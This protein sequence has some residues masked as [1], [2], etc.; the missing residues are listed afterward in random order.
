MKI[1]I[2][3]AA[4]NSN[5]FNISIPGLEL[6]IY[7]VNKCA[8]SFKFDCPV[9]AHP[10]CAQWSRLRN[11]SHYKPFEKYLAP[12]CKYAV[13]KCGGIMEHPS[14]SYYMRNFVPRLSTYSINQSWFGYPGQKKTLLYFN[15]YKPIQHP[16]S[17]NLPPVNNISSLSS[18]L[19]SLTSVS[20]NTWLINC[21]LTAHTN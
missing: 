7:D 10:P 4:T 17:F 19:R 1:A 21:I 9:I 8:Y 3:C 12:F 6:D 5:Y 15:R 18:N 13:D 11:F 20:F 16:L 14:G 2:L